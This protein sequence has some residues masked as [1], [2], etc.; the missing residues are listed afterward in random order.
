MRNRQPA[1]AAGA[2]L[3]LVLAGVTPASADKPGIE[4]PLGPSTSTP[5]YVVP[6]APGVR[7]SSLLTVGDSIGGYRM[8]GVPDGLGAY[9]VD[10]ARLTLLMNHELNDQTGIVR[11]H[12]QIG[13]FVS[14]WSIDRKSF[15]VTAGRDL[16][17]PG[18]QYWDYGAG[19]Y[20]LAPSGS[21]GAA[22]DR[23]CSNTLTDAG[24]LFNET[25]G[26]GYEGRLFFPGEENGNIGRGFA[27][28]TD[29]TIAQL[30]RLGLF[31][32]ENTLPAHNRTDTTL[33]VGNEDE[34]FGQ[35]WIYAG[36]K[37]SAGSPFDRAGLTNGSPSV[38]A[39]A[40]VTSD[41]EFRAAYPKGTPARFTL[42]AIDWTNGDGVTQN[43]E[44]RA[45][46][47][48]LNRIE[49][50]HW[51]PANPNDLYFVT[52]EGGNGAPPAT[53]RFGR[54]GGGLWRLSFD[55]IERPELGGTLTLL[56]DGS[57]PPLLNKPD[58][59]AIDRRGNLLIQEDPGNNVGLARI[60][61]YRI[62]DGARGVLAQFDP[63]LFGWRGGRLPNGNPVLEPGQLTFDEE[64]SGIIDAH[65]VIGPRWFLFDAQVHRNLPDR[66]LFQAGQ[67]LA[68]HVDK[69][70][71]VY[72]SSPDEDSDDED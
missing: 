51:D 57:E 61:A 35:L 43:A 8:V 32:Y 45:K 69:W 60:V 44:A 23:F 18:V 49:D 1:R 37:Q 25:T 33:V 70:N 40:G 34:E 66:E 16:I 48:S 17:N 20:S 36:T 6:V 22:F 65:D 30:P 2:A 10:G 47:L 29:G 56:L 55:D 54:D 4:E 42:N 9:R 50:G 7:T 26:R 3:A 21:F 14:E 13:A 53:G 59:I 68:L 31:S 41:A 64:S 28:T 67:L 58:N 27:L 11:R 72:G 46:G 24:Q 5:P 19:A 52:T 38:A 62:A 39:V 15:E 63:A 71:D 12:G